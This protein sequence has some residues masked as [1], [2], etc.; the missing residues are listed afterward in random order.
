MPQTFNTPS[1]SP[2]R[3]FST[4]LNSP[5]AGFDGTTSPMPES[6]TAPRQ[7]SV[8]SGSPTVSFN[9]NMNSPIRAYK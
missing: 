4:N 5:V 7:H 6:G 1:G 8:P 3:N 2:T 9:V